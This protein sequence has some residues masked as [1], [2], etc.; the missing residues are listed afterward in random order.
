MRDLGAPGG[1]CHAT[2]L[3]QGRGP[4]PGVYWLRLSQGSRRVSSP[5]IF[6]R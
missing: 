4:Q 6:V 2:A 5:L 1:G 3:G